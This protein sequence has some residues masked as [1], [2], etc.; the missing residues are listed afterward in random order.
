MTD[1]MDWQD[2]LL[3]CLFLSDIGTDEVQ[4]IRISDRHYAV[5][6][7]KGKGKNG[8]NRGSNYYHV[9]DGYIAAHD[10]GVGALIGTRG[11]RIK[12]ISNAVGR[13]VTVLDADGADIMERHIDTAKEMGLDIIGVAGHNF[14]RG[15]SDIELY[16]KCVALYRVV[17]DFHVEC[18]KKSNSRI[19]AEKIPEVL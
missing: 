8:G 2:P 18:V 11:E 4:A 10:R 14:V 16:R 17:Y 13:R 12:A 9:V 3:A 5:R 6:L 19:Y 7:D 1:Y 15:V